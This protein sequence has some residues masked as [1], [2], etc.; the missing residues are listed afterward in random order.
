[1]D[2]KDTKTTELDATQQPV[3]P[4]DATT[5]LDDTDDGKTADNDDFSTKPVSLALS[6]GITIDPN[7]AGVTTSD[8]S[9]STDG[10][11]SKPPKP[12]LPRSATPLKI[13][14]PA[15]I[16]TPTSGSSSSPTSSPQPTVA[17]KES[18]PKDYTNLLFENFSARFEQ[19]TAMVQGS[20][21]GVN[22]DLKNMDRRFQEQMDELHAK[23]EAANEQAFHDNVRRERFEQEALARQN[24][25]NAER[26]NTRDGYA[27]SQPFSYDRSHTSVFPPPPQ[28]GFP[29]PVATHR[30]TFTEVRNEIGDLSHQMSIAQGNRLPPTPQRPTPTQFADHYSPTQTANNSASQNGNGT[31]Y[32]SYNSSRFRTN[33]TPSQSRERIGQSFRRDATTHDHFTAR[34]I[35]QIDE[36]EQ[37]LGTPDAPYSYAG[38]NGERGPRDP[39]YGTISAATHQHIRNLNPS[40]NLIHA[41]KSSKI[42]TK[43][44][45]AFSPWSEYWDGVFNSCYLVCLTF[46]DPRHAPITREEWEEMDR[47]EECTH[48]RQQ[49]SRL[50]LSGN[51][52]S[53]SRTDPV[54]TLNG[55]FLGVLDVYQVLLP[56]LVNGMKATLDK[57]AL[58]HIRDEDFCDRISLRLMYFNACLVFL[59]PLSDARQNALSD[60]MTA[61][62]YKLNMSPGE[63]LDKTI[64]KA[65][66]VDKLFQMKQISD[67][68]L[69]TVAFKA[70]RETAGFIYDGCV[71]QFR[72]KEGY[73][74]QDPNMLKEI[75]QVMDTKYKEQKRSADQPYAM[76]VHDGTMSSTDDSS[77]YHAYIAQFAGRGQNGT[78]GGGRF[79]KTPNS[80]NPI[81]KPDL[82]C[83]AMQRNGKCDYPNCKYSH[84]PSVIAKAPP[85]PEK[86]SFIA[87]LLDDATEK[88]VAYTELVAALA[89][90]QKTLSK[91]K[92]SFK[93][94]KVKTAN[95]PKKIAPGTSST[96]QSAIAN[97]ANAL[98]PVS[99]DGNSTAQLTLITSDASDSNATADDDDSSE[100]QD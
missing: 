15:V 60:F 44:T 5:V 93:R 59:A 21:E 92:K 62:V 73:L 47:E 9:V 19:L 58:A 91:T 71:D 77:V 6:E 8:P 49:T 25:A 40:S 31:M 1:M 99:P 85:P 55:V 16:T 53:P 66:K 18:E 41:L 17:T 97:Q 38:A 70:L 10:T 54:L 83:F 64:L 37:M 74:D 2:A 98:I 50:L 32:S 22:Y 69:W 46:I 76:V 24:A 87:M 82:P 67:S 33:R 51:T 88:S 57:S 34:S 84:D 90:T 95:K 72:R 4:A 35:R 45:V 61:T 12:L 36:R 86:G 14:I 42:L 3:V 94:F 26:P 39:H 78:K 28:M 96:Y 65:K 75:F 89:Q 100:D 79:H 56:T 7:Q 43:A 52:P 80:A 68:M 30:T 81:A 48:A 20:Y 13:Q 63:F 11:A 23:Q 27:A 29:P